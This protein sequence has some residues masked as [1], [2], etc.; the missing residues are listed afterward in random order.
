[1]GFAHLMV[2]FADLVLPR[3]IGG[4]AGAAMARAALNRG[5]SSAYS[6]IL[7][8]GWTKT[9]IFIVVAPIMGLVLALFFSS[10]SYWLLRN[11]TP[12]NVDKW[13]RK[14]QLLSAAAYCLGHGATMPRRRWASSREPCSRFD[15]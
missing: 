6:V 9:L 2:G 14:L 4:Y 3:S 15:V 12:R 11:Q 7:P 1:M 13:F 10:A 8:R 5:W